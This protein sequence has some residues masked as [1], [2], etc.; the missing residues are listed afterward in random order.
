MTTPTFSE[1]AAELRTLKASAK[2]AP[3]FAHAGLQAKAD[4]A[5]DELIVAMA[6]TLDAALAE[7]LPDPVIIEEQA[8]PEPQP[9]PEPAPAP[10]PQ[11]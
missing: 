5:Q 1:R 2:A 3:F 10:E 11:A 7:P 8:A 4:A 9:A 6:A